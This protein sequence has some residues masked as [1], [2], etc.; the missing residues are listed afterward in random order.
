[1]KIKDLVTYS[2]ERDCPD[3]RQII[4]TYVTGNHTETNEDNLHVEHRV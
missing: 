4:V 1:M 3:R 2:N